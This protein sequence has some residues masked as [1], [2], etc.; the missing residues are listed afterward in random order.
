MVRKRPQAK[1]W[2]LKRVL[3]GKPLKIQAHIDKGTGRCEKSLW[4]KD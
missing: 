4:G 3:E 1:N 2:Y